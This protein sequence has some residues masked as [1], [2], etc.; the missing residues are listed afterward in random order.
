[1]TR[2]W[3]EGS[4]LSGGCYSVKENIKFKTPMSNLCDCSDACI[5]VKWKMTVEGTNNVKKINKN[6]IF[7]NNAPFGLCI[8]KIKNTLIDNA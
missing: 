3:I 7:V 6:L 5:V 8:L 1:M 4:N 2:T